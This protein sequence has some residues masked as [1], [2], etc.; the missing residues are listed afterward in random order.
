MQLPTQN[1][2]IGGTKADN[3]ANNTLTSDSIPMGRKKLKKYGQSNNN[4]KGSPQKKPSN[5]DDQVVDVSY[6]QYLDDKK[7]GF[8]IQRKPIL[9]GACNLRGYTLNGSDKP[10]EKEDVMCLNNEDFSA[11]QTNLNKA[12]KMF[13]KSMDIKSQS[14][15][16]QEIAKITNKFSRMHTFKKF[17]K[18]K[19]A[20]DVEVKLYNYKKV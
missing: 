3:V 17:Q 19:E 18:M 5:V 7:F 14:D 1:L 2:L 4:G 13:Q 10:Q 12:I 8:D 9:L 20:A 16:D 15:H 6:K 11:V